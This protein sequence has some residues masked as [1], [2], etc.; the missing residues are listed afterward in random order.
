MH[1]AGAIAPALFVGERRL[2]GSLPTVR[3]WER[4]HRLSG[5]G[6]P[7]AQTA[8]EPTCRKQIPSAVLPLSATP[9]TPHR[10]S[11]LKRRSRKSTWTTTCRSARPS[12]LLPPPAIRGRLTYSLVSG[13]G[14]ADNASFTIDGNSLKTATTYNASL[15]STYT[16]RVRTTDQNGLSFESN[17]TIAVNDKTPPT[18]NHQSEKS[19]KPIRPMPAHLFH[20]DV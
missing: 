20:R 8:D 11:S 16:I 17:F 2:Y 14:S 19:D 12:G 10:L 1:R 4:L 5:M 3:T 15:K 13:T 6:A 7:S 18:R 9:P